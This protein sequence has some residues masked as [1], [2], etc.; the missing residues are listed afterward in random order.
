MP[1]FDA[2]GNQIGKLWGAV[3]TDT[4]F[5][6]RMERRVEL[7]DNRVATLVEGHSMVP[8][9]TS[10]TDLVYLMVDVVSSAERFRA[11]RLMHYP[12]GWTAT[13]YDE[14]YYEVEPTPWCQGLFSGARGMAVFGYVDDSGESPVGVYQMISG[15]GC[16]FQA[17]IA[18]PPDIQ[19]GAHWYP[20]SQV[21]PFA[22]HTDYSLG[23][24]LMLQS[25][26]RDSNLEERNILA[27][28]TPIFV[29][30]APVS[31]HMW[32]SGA[33]EPVYDE[34]CPE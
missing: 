29:R 17:V 7:L 33:I 14:A 10:A 26:G 4:G 25:K 23:K 12:G 15:E 13:A 5:R 16:G 9:L 21:G 30:Y 19:D 34:E 18:G 11:R 3:R 27:T 6:R 32:F 20:W 22:Q 28:A 24:A 31:E 2:I 8:P 1:I